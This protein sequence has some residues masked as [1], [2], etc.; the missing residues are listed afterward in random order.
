VKITHQRDI[1]VKS[2]ATLGK[3]EAYKGMALAV[4]VYKAQGKVPAGV[5]RGLDGY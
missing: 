2:N 1:E 3:I 5:G 4:W